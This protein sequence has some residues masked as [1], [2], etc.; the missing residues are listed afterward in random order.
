MIDKLDFIEERYEELN[1]AI[2]DPD[3]ISNQDE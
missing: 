3:I 2:S 1:R